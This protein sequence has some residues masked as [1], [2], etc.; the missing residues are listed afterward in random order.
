MMQTATISKPKITYKTYRYTTTLYW[1]GNRSGILASGDKQEFR[2]AS[3]PEFHG[4]E[5]VWTPEDLFVGAVNTC[6]MTTFAAFAERVQLPVLSY[7]STAQGILEVVNGKYQFTKIILQPHIILHS[8]D[9]VEEA[10][11]TLDE[12]H[13]KCIIS[14]SIH[15]E[16]I[17]EPII[18]VQPQKVVSF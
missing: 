10:K 5:G 16:V 8:A 2:V 4:E 17:V 13:Q 7:C 18:E 3:P 1:Q 14:N 6:M 15:S 9:V 12:A 11:K